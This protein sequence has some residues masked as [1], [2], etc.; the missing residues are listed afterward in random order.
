MIRDNYVQ[1]K[2]NGPVCPLRRLYV[3]PWQRKT[4][5]FC[6]SGLL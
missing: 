4:E 3:I 1:E 5:E 6:Q 2:A